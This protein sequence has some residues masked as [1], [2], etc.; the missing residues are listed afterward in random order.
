MLEEMITLLRKGGNEHWANY[1]QIAKEFYLSG[2]TSKSYSKVLGAY[3]GMGS[4]ND[5][6][7]NL[8]QEEHERMEYLR[9]AI[10]TYSKEHR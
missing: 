7:W 1:F 2:K 6:F 10:W 4:F 5:T 8:P 3:G 9:D